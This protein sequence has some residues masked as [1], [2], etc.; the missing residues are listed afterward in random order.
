MWEG[1]GKSHGVGEIYVDGSGL[2]VAVVVLVPLQSAGCHSS[3]RGGQLVKDGSV[4]LQVLAMRAPFLISQFDSDRKCKRLRPC[5][6]YCEGL[7][8][9]DRDCASSDSVGN[10]GRFAALVPPSEPVKL[11]P[12]LL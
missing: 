1:Q 6:K 7:L 9:T 10:S 4:L 11:V 3:E 2:L 12:V 8:R 5:W